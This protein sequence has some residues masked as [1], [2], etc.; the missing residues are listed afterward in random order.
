[1]KVIEADTLISKMESLGKRS[2]RTFVIQLFWCIE[3]R[4]T[5]TAELTRKQI[6][7]IINNRNHTIVSK[8]LD[9]GFNVVQVI[10]IV[11]SW[12]SFD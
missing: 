8:S 9:K 7:V 6:L 3:V 4:N 12:G 5:F 10:H 2:Q 11:D 1:V